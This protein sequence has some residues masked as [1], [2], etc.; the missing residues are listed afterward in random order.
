MEHGF[1]EKQKD[2]FRETFKLFDR[3][4]DGVISSRELE[5]AM[6]NVGCNPTKEDVDAM[7]DA[8]DTN[9]NGVVEFDEFVSMLAS[10][11]KA[12]EGQEKEGSK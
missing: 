7:I 12:E 10:R 11:M 3:N 8:I 5:T 6:R 4:N 1:T 2:E 9:R